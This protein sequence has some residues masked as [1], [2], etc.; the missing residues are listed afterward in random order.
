MGM[1]RWKLGRGSK[2]HT[3]FLFLKREIEY[4]FTENKMRDFKMI[5]VKISMLTNL[6]YL[7][8]KILTFPINKLCMWR[9]WYSKLRPQRDFWICLLRSVRFDQD[10]NLASAAIL[11]WLQFAQL[12]AALAFLLFAFLLLTEV[13]SQTHRKVLTQCTDFLNF[14]TAYTEQVCYWSTEQIHG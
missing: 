10:T 7:W 5:L 9:L 6:K 14:E 8:P 11:K 13:S 3:V 2:G 12:I 1:R 4:M